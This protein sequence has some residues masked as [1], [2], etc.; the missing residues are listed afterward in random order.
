M[1]ERD[2]KIL[3]AAKRYIRVVASKS[4]RVDETQ[5]RIALVAAGAGAQAPDVVR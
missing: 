2:Q 3:E 4:T 5:A 1:N